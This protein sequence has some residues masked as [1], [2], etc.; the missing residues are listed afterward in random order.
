M[1]FKVSKR[2]VDA[3]KPRERPFIAFDTELKGFGVRVY[4][5]GLK[6]YVVEYRPGAGGRAVSKRRHKLGDAG[7]LTPDQARRA[8]QGAL[9]TI[10]LGGDPAADRAASRAQMPVGDLIDEFIAGIEAKK[11][12]NTADGY[13][14]ILNKHVRPKFGT[15]KAIAFDRPSLSKHH[16]SLKD[17]PYAAN[18]MLAVVSSM[19][20]FA[21]ERHLVPEGFNP[22]RGIVRFPESPREKFL[23]GKELD[24]L[25]AALREAET[26]GLP[27]NLVADGAQ[28][29]H[30]P[31]KD[32]RFTRLSPH[33]VAA[34]RLLLFTGCRLRGNPWAAME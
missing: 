20:R 11:K 15:R 16:L 31:K 10:R 17:D 12:A 25:G 4:P 32:R 7:A 29:K 5:S 33:A 30:T 1:T 9:A 2:T 26:T 24:R 8:A 6:A 23:S 34:V 13:R 22:A 27:W 28:A 14:L 18:K 19:Y 3:L 21:A